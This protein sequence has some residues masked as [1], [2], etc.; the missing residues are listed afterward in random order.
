MSQDWTS[1]FVKVT[2]CQ[3]CGGPTCP[4]IL[5]DD[6]ENVPQPGFIGT[7]YFE[8][9]I[10]LVGQNPAVPRESMA[11]AD[12]R[13]TAALRAVRDNRSPES[14]SALQAVLMEFVPSWRVQ[15]K[16]FPLAEAGLALE[17]IAYCNLVRCRTYANAKPSFSM[18]SACSIH[19]IHWLDMLKPR[20]V[21][22]I[23]KWSHDKGA[24]FV[25]ER[26]IPFDFMNRLRNLSSQKRQEN[27]SRVTALICATTNE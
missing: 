17:D 25:E 12:R 15:Q 6:I 13:Y 11:T 1:E 4:K 14:W 7:H 20:L 16:Y 5:R 3:K 19:F 18:L 21:V 22:F 2:S 8:K 26:H 23:G 10:L 27:R 24:K 9:R